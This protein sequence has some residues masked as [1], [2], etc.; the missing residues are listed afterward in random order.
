VKKRGYPGLSVFTI[1]FGKLGVRSVLS[2]TDEK[3]ISI[4]VLGKA[5]LI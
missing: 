3:S 2:E 1:T 4:G 5:V